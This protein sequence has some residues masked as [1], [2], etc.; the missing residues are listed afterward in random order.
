MRNGNGDLFAPLDAL[1]DCQDIHDLVG[2]ISE[3]ESISINMT[4]ARRVDA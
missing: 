4:A 1:A 3:M 2:P